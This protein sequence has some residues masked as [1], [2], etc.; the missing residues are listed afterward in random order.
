MSPAA[1]V[2]TTANLFF[3][4]EIGH[5]LLNHRVVMAPQTK[6]RTINTSALLKVVKEYYFQRGSISGTFSISEGTAFGFDEQI[7]TW[8]EVSGVSSSEIIVDCLFHASCDPTYDVVSAGDIP[9]AEGEGPT[10]ND[11]KTRDP[12][13]HRRF[14]IG[15]YQ[16]CK[17]DG[18]ELPGTYGF[19]IDQF[20]GDVS[21]SRTD[22]YGGSIE[23]RVRF[24]LEVVDAVAKAVGEDKTA[25]RFSPWTRDRA[26]RETA[27]F[28]IPSSHQSRDLD[29]PEQS[30]ENF[31]DMWSPRLLVVADG[32]T[33]EKAFLRKETP[34]AEPRL[35]DEGMEGGNEAGWDE[36][37]IAEEGFM[38]RGLSMWTMSSD[39]VFRMRVDVYYDTVENIGPQS[40]T[41][42]P[43]VHPVLTVWVAAACPSKEGRTSYV[44]IL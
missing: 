35:L 22:K 17:A 39:Q 33:R 19:L 37:R 38:V 42:A 8:K 20:I 28:G 23:N 18:V 21:N 13:I 41:L 26:E 3:P 40:I 29:D 15:C 1:R 30:N 12:D 43:Y 7:A 25:I 16:C 27:R 6:L 10:T 32:F 9:V 4:I 14:R 34:V 36:E 44:L 5:M 31:F 2:A 11:G 24:A